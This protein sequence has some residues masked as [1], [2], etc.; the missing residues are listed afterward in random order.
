MRLECSWS[1]CSR[2]PSRRWKWLCWAQSFQRMSLWEDF[3]NLNHNTSSMVLTSIWIFINCLYIWIWPVVPTV[4]EAAAYWSV[5]VIA[6]ITG[7]RC[8]RIYSCTSPLDR[9]CLSREYWFIHSSATVLVPRG[10]IRR[11]KE[12]LGHRWCQALEITGCHFLVL[13]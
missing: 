10:Y 13:Y 7:A 6:M 3:S 4:P 5:L 9:F 8:F 1:S 12:Y 2:G 11:L